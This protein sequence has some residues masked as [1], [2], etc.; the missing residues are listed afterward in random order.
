[1]RIINITNN[2]GALFYAKD[3]L[4]GKLPESKNVA[5]PIIVH[6]EIRKNLLYMKSLNE[7]I[8]G[9]MIWVGYQFDII[10]STLIGKL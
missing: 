6:P 1:M 9:L 4:Q 10:N 2:R 5:D 7:G 3:R 8:R